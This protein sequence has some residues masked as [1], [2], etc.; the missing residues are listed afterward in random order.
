MTRHALVV[1]DDASMVKTL[2]DIL[3]LQ[4]WQVTTATTG[5][6]AVKLAVTQPFDVVLMDVRMPGMDG[7]AALKAMKEARRDLPV[8]LMTA[9][10]AEDRLAEAERAGVLRILSKPVDIGALLTLLT[11]AIQARRP[12]L[13]IDHDAAFLKTLSE[14]LELQGFETV[15][16]GTLE[17]GRR[18]AME[19]S[20]R[21]VLLHLHL[22][23][24]SVRDAVRAVHAAGPAMVL[25][26]YSGR[27]GA[28]E[29]VNEVVPREWI[30]AYL[31]KPFAVEE[32]TGV[33]DAI[34]RAS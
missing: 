28:A 34:R 21:A 20:P 25:V 31:Q 16:A 2:G 9:Y 24:V 26:V 32:L 1:D 6:T 12:V 22:G 29:E 19:R 4:G 7:V 14:V 8:V 10:A 3:Q 18:L 13:L 33:L 17:E 23:P 30:H 5:T 27:P 11:S 15:L